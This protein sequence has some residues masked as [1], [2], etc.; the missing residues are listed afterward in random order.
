[1]FSKN[2]KYNYFD[3]GILNKLS[4]DLTSAITNSKLAHYRPQMRKLRH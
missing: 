2:R 1:M 4:E 3:I